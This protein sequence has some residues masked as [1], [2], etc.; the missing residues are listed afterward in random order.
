MTIPPGPQ[1]RAIPLK[2]SVPATGIAGMPGEVQERLE[3]RRIALII[4]RSQEK[5]TLGIGMM[6]ALSNRLVQEAN[7]VASELRRPVA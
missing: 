7:S 1:T 2:S 4:K 5:L 3:H 6:E